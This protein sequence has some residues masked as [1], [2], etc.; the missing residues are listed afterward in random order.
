MNEQQITLISNK[1]LSFI[2]PPAH[3]IP[4]SIL[5]H[6]KLLSLFPLAPRSILIDNLAALY[7]VNLKIH[8]NLTPAILDSRFHNPANSLY[9]HQIQAQQWLQEELIIIPPLPSPLPPTYSIQAHVYSHIQQRLSLFYHNSETIL[10][11]KL[12]RFNI[13]PQTINSFL[14]L[15]HHIINT[16]LK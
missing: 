3:W 15:V 10:L 12:Q 5:L 4:L 7:R 1:L 6:L 2:G 13:P 11:N 8:S 9:H 14:E 16:A